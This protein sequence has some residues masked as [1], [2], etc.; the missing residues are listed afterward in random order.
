MTAQIPIPQRLRKPHPFVIATRQAAAAEAP[1]ADGRITV[2]GGGVVHLVVSPGLV[3]RRLLILQALLVAA[4]RRRYAVQAIDGST[5]G[6]PGVA[7]VV[8]GHV[9]PVQITELQS[10][11]PVTEEDI[12]AWRRANRWYLMLGAERTPPTTKPM[13]NGRLRLTLPRPWADGRRCNWADTS[14]GTVESKLASVLR[15]LERRAEAD[16]RDAAETA[17]RREEYRREQA[18]RFAL[19][20]QARVE[21]ARIEQLER[22]TDAWRLARDARDYAAALRQR[23]LLRADRAERNRLNS[24]CV[25]IEDWAE[26]IDPTGS[27]PCAQSEGTSEPS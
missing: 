23:V 12:A 7:F 5:I 11:V 19:E 22:E 16:T 27:V 9:Y 1:A 15:E 3:R 20:Q 4:K 25:W 24:Y 26:R 17:R 2:V 21:G 8:A 6:P 13:A 10:P 18:R 14:R